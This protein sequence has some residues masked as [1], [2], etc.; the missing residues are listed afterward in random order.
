MQVRQNF[1]DASCLRRVLLT[2]ELHLFE[3]RFCQEVTG[4]NSVSQTSQFLTL[5]IL[6]QF[7]ISHCLESSMPAHAARCWEVRFTVARSTR[8]LL[9]SIFTGF[10][11]GE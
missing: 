1:L 11:M 2:M 9:T 3:Q 7:G 10:S 4:A 6:G 8:F 5:K